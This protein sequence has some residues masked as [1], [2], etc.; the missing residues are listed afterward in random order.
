[1]QIAQKQESTGI[2]VC[3]VSIPDSNSPS[4]HSAAL[5]VRLALL[6]WIPPGRSKL[7]LPLFQ[8]TGFD[9]VVAG[10]LPGYYGF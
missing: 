4:G 6:V 10:L 7:A 1:M 3:Q 2:K 9:G 8:M 5:L